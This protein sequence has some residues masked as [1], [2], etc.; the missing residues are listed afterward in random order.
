MTMEMQA[1]ILKSVTLPQAP[2]RPRAPPPTG[3]CRGD[4]CGSSPL[5][6][7]SRESFSS[8]F[9]CLL[10]TAGLGDHSWVFL[11]PGGGGGSG[12]HCGREERVFGA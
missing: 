1:L 6:P 7:P 5:C 10:P 9:L 11:G 2:S 4:S 3:V 8:Q 12:S